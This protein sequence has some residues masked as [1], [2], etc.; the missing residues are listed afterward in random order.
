MIGDVKAR[1]VRSDGIETTLGDGEW[2]I[3]NDGLE[4]WANL[5]Y[6]VKSAEVPS[7]DGAIV[8]AKRVSSVDRTIKATVGN[9]R[10]NE[11][12]RARA[13][14]FF[15]PKHSYDVYLTYM[16]RTRWCHGEQIGFKASEGNIYD[17]VTI[18]WTILCPN[19]YLLSVGDFGK[20]IAEVMGR[21]GFPFI[22]ALPVSEGSQPGFIEG[23]VTSVRAFSTTVEIE[24]DGD[25]P[26]GMRVRIKAGGRV[27]NPVV[28]VGKGYIRLVVEMAENDE[29]ELDASSRPPVIKMNGENAMQLLDRRSSILDMTVA[30]GGTTIEYG[31][32]DGEGNMSV[33]VRYNKQY[34]GV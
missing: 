4:N 27:L 12:L 15:N 9:T 7:Y 18:E 17:P 23:F 2:R 29:I 34:L 33:V 1:I 14:K 28:K 3:P 20:D 21:F 26:S 8:T 5:P 24:N 22:S 13:I 31:A 19:P 30:V 25:V 6:S 32:D 11:K 10:D 16:G